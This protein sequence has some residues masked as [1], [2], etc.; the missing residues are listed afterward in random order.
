MAD[1]KPLK[2]AVF[3]SG[4]GSNVQAIL[5]HIKSGRLNAQIVLMISSSASAGAMDIARDNSIPGFFMTA[6]Q[7]LEEKDYIA[8]LL[9][10]LQQYETE[11]VV[12]AGYLKI[13]PAAVVKQYHQ[14]IINIHP[15]LLPSFGGK[16]LYGRHVHEAVLNYGC[17]ISGAT[18]HM[19]D[20]EYDTGA[21]LIQRCVPVL[22]DDTPESL[23]ARV[24]TAEHQILAEA[25]QL[26][27][28]N[29][30]RVQGRKVIISPEKVEPDAAIRC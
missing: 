30:V 22:E 19:V 28:E 13:I 26:F 23:A 16:G 4:R 11:L 15:A 10:L 12:L 17:K 24:L 14:R 7:Y 3:V 6:K 8:A 29:R 20:I 1:T 18:V 21:P 5:D 2:I 25:V 27:A 9:H